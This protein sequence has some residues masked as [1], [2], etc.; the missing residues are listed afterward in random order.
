MKKDDRSLILSLWPVDDEATR[1]WM[2]E[3]YRGRFENKLSTAQSVREACLAVLAKRRE[4]N[5]SVHPFYWA[6]FKAVGDWR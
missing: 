4:Q 5:Q 3:L 1:A 6:A 2:V